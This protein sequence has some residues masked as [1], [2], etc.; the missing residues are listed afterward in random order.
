[1]PDTGELYTT[2]HGVK[3]TDLGA[4]S[5]AEAAVMI[6]FGNGI[7]ILADMGTNVYRTT[8]YGATWT[9]LGAVLNAAASG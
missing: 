1:M 5:A 7:A 6:A 8:D 9:D 2:D 3:W 4:I